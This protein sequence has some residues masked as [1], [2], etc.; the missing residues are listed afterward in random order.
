MS[1]NSM[2]G[3]LSNANNHCQMITNDNFIESVMI[4]FSLTR[5]DYFL[6]GKLDSVIK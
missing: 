6:F 3:L 2:F 1:R 5:L 4:L